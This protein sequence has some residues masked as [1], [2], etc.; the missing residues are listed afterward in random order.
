MERRLKWHAI[1]N[2]CGSMSVQGMLLML[3]MDFNI[4]IGI[5][6]I[7]ISIKKFIGSSY[8]NV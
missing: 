7:I 4:F 2:L 5:L 8:R 6:T 1:K 3:E